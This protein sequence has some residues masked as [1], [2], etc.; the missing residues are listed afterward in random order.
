MISKFRK[1][2]DSLLVRILLGLIAFSFVGVGGDAFI[3]G[4]SSGDVISFSETD[5]ISFEEFHI[6]KAK[7]IESLQRQNGINL[8][9]ENIAELGID[10]S[11]LKKLINDSMISYLAK[12]Y[13]FD[14]SDE[15]VIAYVKKTPF[16]KNKLI[17]K[18]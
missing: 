6:A 1:G 18:F 11:V 8:T 17:A 3:N 9:E 4:N 7:E 5:S 15:K 16:F 13:E 14:I 2:A 12:Y 10:N